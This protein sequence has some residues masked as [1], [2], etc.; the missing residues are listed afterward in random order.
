MHDTD[1]RLAYSL[2]DAADA[3]GLSLRKLA[4]MV[5]TGEIRSFRAGRRRLVSVSAL[6][7]YISRQECE[8]ELTAA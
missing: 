2:E 8:H 5:A 7:E 6:R 3:I 4:A 1:I